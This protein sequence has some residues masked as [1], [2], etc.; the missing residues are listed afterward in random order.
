MDVVLTRFDTPKCH[1][2]TLSHN[3]LA[4]SQKTLLNFREAIHWREQPAR[5]RKMV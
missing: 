3:L 2:T 5:A 1:P 4:P